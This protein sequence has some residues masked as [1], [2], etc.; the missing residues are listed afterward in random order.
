[1]ITA[2]AAA[3]PDGESAIYRKLAWRRISSS[4]TRSTAWARD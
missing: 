1:M 4:A 3:A 2:A